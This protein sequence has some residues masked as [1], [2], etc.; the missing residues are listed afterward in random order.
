MNC[1]IIGGSS[2]LG[3]AL[4]RKLTAEYDVHVTGRRDPGD[5]F[6]QF[7][8]LDLS[9]SDGL[10]ERVQEAVHHVWRVDLLIYAAGFYQEGTITELSTEQIHEMLNVGLVAAMYTAQ[11]VLLA[12]KLGGFIA[13]TSTSQ[14]TPRLLEPVYTAAKAGLGA[15][16]N[17][18]S[19]DPRV[20]K[21]L[22]VGP[23]GMDT[24]FWSGTD[25]DT[26]GMLDPNWVAEQTLTLYDGDFSY[27]FAH[28]L[29][30]PERAEV[31]E[32]RP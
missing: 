3:L 16:A 19:L 25:K 6:I 31:K 14:W 10:R 21:T 8:S 29:R 26:T 18:L 11:E 22:V 5:R 23:A 20:G 2:G 27:K 30:G 24:S 1:L 28:I 15:F 7:I 17:S 12:Q 4:A 13:I 32:T 9:E